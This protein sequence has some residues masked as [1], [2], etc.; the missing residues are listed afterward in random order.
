MVDGLGVDGSTAVACFRSARPTGTGR[1]GGWRVECNSFARV[2]VVGSLS[3]LVVEFEGS[4]MVVA[5]RV[6][7][8]IGMG[9]G[10]KLFLNGW[11]TSGSN[12][13]GSTP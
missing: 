5:M 12:F 8:G 4:L 9:F 10:S 7:I 1:S 6:V 3:Q 11:G 2:G 13:T